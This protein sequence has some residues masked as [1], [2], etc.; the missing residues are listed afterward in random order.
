MKNHLEVSDV[1][2]HPCARDLRSTG[3]RGWATVTLN[4]ALILDSLQVRRTLDGRNVISFPTRTDANGVEHTYYRAASIA[5]RSALE[6][7][8]LRAL[9]AKGWVSDGV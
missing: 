8:V 6:S 9:A 1:R 4:D 5:S 7:Q 3:L 2:F